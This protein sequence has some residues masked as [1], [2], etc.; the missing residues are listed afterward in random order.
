MQTFSFLKLL[1]DGFSCPGV[2]SCRNRNEKKSLR[3]ES[4]EESKALS[5]WNILAKKEPPQSSSVE[6]SSL[7]SSRERIERF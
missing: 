5:M 3:G 2:S 7:S 4:Q 6:S 1:R